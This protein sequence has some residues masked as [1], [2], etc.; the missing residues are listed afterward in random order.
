MYPVI[1]FA[2]SFML[3]ELNLVTA[4]ETSGSK[5]YEYGTRPALT[6]PRSAIYPGNKGFLTQMEVCGYVF[7]V[8]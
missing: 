6:K 1:I 5:E 4:A 8:K 3:V 2:L 7:I